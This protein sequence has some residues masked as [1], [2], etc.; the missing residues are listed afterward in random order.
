VSART[1]AMTA[2]RA[3]LRDRKRPPNTPSF[4][5]RPKGGA[6]NPSRRSRAW[7]PDSRGACH[8]A[9]PC[10]DPLAAS[11]MTLKFWHLL[12]C[13]CVSPTP[14][15]LLFERRGV[16]LV[17]FFRSLLQEG[18]GAPGGAR[19]LRGPTNGPGE[20][21]FRAPYKAGLRGLPWDARPLRRK[22][23]RLPALHQPTRTLCPVSAP[24]GWA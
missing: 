17:P 10:A 8:R 18:N 4:R 16:R 12:C 21:P 2:L 19:G 9:A 23:L 14:P 6:R 1:I 24:K 3:M 13:R 20:G 7:S 5:G 22:G 11:G 15:P